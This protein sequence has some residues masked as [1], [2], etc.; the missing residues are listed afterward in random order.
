VYMW[1]ALSHGQILV[2]AGFILLGW[3]S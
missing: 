2:G 1:M 3:E